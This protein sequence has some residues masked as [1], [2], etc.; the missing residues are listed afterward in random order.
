MLCIKQGNNE[1]RY[2]YIY[3]NQEKKAPL[4]SDRFGKALS[5]YC[6]ELTVVDNRE[7]KPWLKKFKEHDYDKVIISRI[8]CDFTIEDITFRFH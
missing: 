2:F 3:E 8:L 5:Y 4:N 7:R 6:K 1:K